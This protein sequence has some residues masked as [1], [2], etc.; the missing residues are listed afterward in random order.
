LFEARNGVTFSSTDALEF[1]ETASSTLEAAYSFGLR[2]GGVKPTNV[3]MA[4]MKTGGKSS[5]EV[6]SATFRSTFNEDQPRFYDRRPPGDSGSTKKYSNI[7]FDSSLAQEDS[8]DDVRERPSSISNRSR[9]LLADF[10]LSPL[11]PGVGSS[12]D[13]E[14]CFAAPEFDSAARSNGA[15]SPYTQPSDAR[16]VAADVFGV[17]AC[18]YFM[19]TGASPV[20]FARGSGARER[21]RPIAKSAPGVD[22]ATAE[23]I[24]RCLADSPADR[25]RSFAEMREAATTSRRRTIE[26]ERR[27]STPGSTYSN[28]VGSLR[29]LVRRFLGR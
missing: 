8:D 28:G 18:A 22:S 24:M 26:T 5:F 9:F 10:G 4:I 23:V 15:S 17:G 29:S 14:N 7:G 1:I 20:S 11:H 27:R 3:F 16:F 2:H 25:F 6:D 21:V 19:L 13:R 12:L